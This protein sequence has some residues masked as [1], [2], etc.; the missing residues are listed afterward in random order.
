VIG[1][2]KWFADPRPIKISATA[3]QNHMLVS[4]LSLKTETHLWSHRPMI[5]GSY[6]NK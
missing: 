4:R 2:S 1:E 5:N 3:W 6:E